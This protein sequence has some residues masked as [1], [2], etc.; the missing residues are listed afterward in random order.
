MRRHILLILV[1]TL[2]PGCWVYL[3][4]TT[5]R[6]SDIDALYKYRRLPPGGHPGMTKEELRA[7]YG[8]SGSDLTLNDDESNA[9]YFSA[10]ECPIWRYRF[11]NNHLIARGYLVMEG[12]VWGYVDTD[13]KKTRRKKIPIYDDNKKIIGLRLIRID[14]KYD[15]DGN[16]VGEE[17]TEEE[18][19]PT[20]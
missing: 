18:S 5:Y 1:F 6:C 2:L 15:K 20:E 11:E 8:K 4:P 14:P 9:I 3:S 10:G 13:Y 7:S 12:G 17:R 16:L 19:K